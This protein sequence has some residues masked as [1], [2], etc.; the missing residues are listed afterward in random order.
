[1]E[2][3]DEQ[4][5]KLLEILQETFDYGEIEHID[6]LEEIAGIIGTIDDD[7]EIL[8]QKIKTLKKAKKYL[9]KIWDEGEIE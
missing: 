3:K 9:N 7:L 2:I 8:E 5:E 4:N 6:G 1:M